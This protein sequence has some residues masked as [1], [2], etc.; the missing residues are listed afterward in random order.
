M[1]AWLGVLTGPV[2]EV[3]I[4]VLCILCQI[5]H[6]L[7]TAK[8][9]KYII[10]PKYSERRVNKWQTFILQ[11]WVPRGEALLVQGEKIYTLGLLM[12]NRVLWNQAQRVRELRYNFGGR[13]FLS[14]VRPSCGFYQVDERS[15]VNHIIPAGLSF[16]T[17]ALLNSQLR[18][19][20]L[21]LCSYSSTSLDRGFARLYT[22]PMFGSMRWAPDLEHVRSFSVW[23]CWD[24]DPVWTDSET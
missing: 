3:E 24:L 5:H 4:S 14:G 17:S 11:W 19:V 1:P 21:V 2:C 15:N 10:L 9:H 8:V 12:G 16:K 7:S 20:D 6:R 23:P 22:S 13:G 18:L